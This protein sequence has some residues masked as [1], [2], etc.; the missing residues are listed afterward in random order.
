MVGDETIAAI[1]ALI[2]GT[3]MLVVMFFQFDTIAAYDTSAQQAA[4]GIRNGMQYLAA[5]DMGYRIYKQYSLGFMGGVPQFT[6]SVDSQY[7]YVKHVK[8][9]T[10]AQL[11]H[12]TEKVTSTG[13]LTGKEFCI[14]KNLDSNCNPQVK[15]CL[16]SDTS[17]C[18]L[19]LGSCTYGPIVPFTVGAPKLAAAPAEVA[20]SSEVGTPCTTT[21]TDVTVDQY[22]CKDGNAQYSKILQ[23]WSCDTTVG[24]CKLSATTTQEGY[25]QVS[26]C[27][28][29]QE[30]DASGAIA[31]CQAISGTGADT[32][33]AKSVGTSM[34]TDAQKERTAIYTERTDLAVN[35]VTAFA[36]QD[37][38]GVLSNGLGLAKNYLA[39]GVTWLKEGAGTLLKGGA[40]LVDG[41]RNFACGEKCTFLGCFKIC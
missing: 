31:K 12:Y 29:G 19:A 21:C 23:D 2:I 10:E 33:L 35:T 30:C 41:A 38:L 20:V 22:M 11:P 13:T 40:E 18:S 7:I 15:V 34:I 4:L 3:T 24:Q 37:T 39:E 9:K 32:I 5:A 36:K 1:A 25:P 16:A 8:G 26:T 17:C 6:V 27:T 14:V 28:F